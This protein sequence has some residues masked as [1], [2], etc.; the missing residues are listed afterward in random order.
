M[1]RDGSS[2]VYQKINL[3][4]KLGWSVSIAPKPISDYLKSVN[5]SNLILFQINEITF[6]SGFFLHCNYLRNWDIEHIA[7]YL[8]ENKQKCFQTNVDF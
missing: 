6:K 1:S 8:A 3:K 5:K 4:A 7:N 2:C